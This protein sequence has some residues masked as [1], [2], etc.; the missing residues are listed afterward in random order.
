MKVIVLSG[1]NMVEGGILT[2]Y[3]SVLQSLSRQR[4][5]K[6]ICL[7]HRKSLFEGFFS[8]DSCV[9]FLEFPKI[10]ERWF[11]RIYFEFVTSFFISKNLKPDLWI[12]LHDISANV[13][14]VEQMVYCHNPSP[15][16]KTKFKDFFYDKKFFL[17]TIFYKL[18]YKLNI[19]KNH[20]VF[21][22]QEW[23]AE[24]FHKW[25]NVKNL[26]VTRPQNKKNNEIESHRSSRRKIEPRREIINLFY[27]A[28]PR[29]FKNIE[30]IINAMAY[31]KENRPD[32]Y[33]RVNI[34]IT[35]D[36][37]INKYSNYMYRCISNNNLDNIK[38]LGLLSSEEVNDFYRDRC[39]Y[40]LFPSK[41]ETWGLP[42][43][44]AK[45]YNIPVVA[46]DLPYAHETIGLYD[47]CK[48]FDPNDEF[49]LGN[50]IT[51]A[52]NNDL[53]LDENNSS[54]DCQWPGLNDWDEFCAYLIKSIKQA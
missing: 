53:Q 37:T 25:Y 39:D 15:F 52:V 51:D 42:L 3:R 26:Y 2:I 21:V 35:L 27:P 41:L 9:E 49:L 17:F 34:Y 12:C 10:K 36:E 46:A 30:I 45:E 5:V 33:Q 18:L 24:C 20:T 13:H 8:E 31:L 7:V 22:Q 6:I 54:I 43:T 28:F 40:L 38:L 11:S 47:K 48:F 14:N 1:V 19:K 23:I 4:N 16:Y 32:I 29:V 44:E 50:I